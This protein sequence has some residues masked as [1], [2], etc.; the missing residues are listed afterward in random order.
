MF[1]AFNS[2]HQERY[3]GWVALHHS[4]AGWIPDW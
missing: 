3:S 2:S 1:V 4:I